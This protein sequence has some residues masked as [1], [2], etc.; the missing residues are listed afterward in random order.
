MSNLKTHPRPEQA[1]AAEREMLIDHRE[2]LVTLAKR[3]R[4]ELQTPLQRRCSSG[5]GSAQ[6]MWR[7]IA[8]I[9]RGESQ[10]AVIDLQLKSLGTS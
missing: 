10:I 7:M 4:T 8:A 5:L 2:E 9:R 1:I 6:A 3:Y